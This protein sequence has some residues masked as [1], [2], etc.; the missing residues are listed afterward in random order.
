MKSLALAAATLLFTTGCQSES[1]PQPESVA[2]PVSFDFG[3][4]KT[5]ELHVPDMMCQY[6]CAA[7]V[8]E[9][10]TA[11]AGVTE[12]KVDFDSKRVGL[13]IDETEFDADAAV[14]A[15]VDFS[16]PNTKLMQAKLQAE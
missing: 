11:Q 13:A 16:F 1:V 6:G 2:T 7:K 5:A 3:D 15:L 9:V 10:L 4:A 12:V 14:A 8:E